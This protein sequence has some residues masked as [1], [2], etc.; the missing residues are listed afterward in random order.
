[1][2]LT[3]NWESKHEVTRNDWND[4]KYFIKRERD[5]ICHW[6]KKAVIVKKT[7]IKD[8]EIFY[9]VIVSTAKTL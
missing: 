6:H 4:Y 3:E 8:W 1:L 7:M 2:Q 5:E 9:I